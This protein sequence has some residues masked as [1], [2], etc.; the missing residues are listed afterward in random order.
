MEYGGRKRNDEK[1]K[2]QKIKKRK[3]KDELGMNVQSLGAHISIHFNHD[4][5]IRVDDNA[6]RSKPFGW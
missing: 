2:D 5:R 1:E 3:W 6:F 4:F